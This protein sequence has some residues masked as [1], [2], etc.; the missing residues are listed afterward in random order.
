MGMVKDNKNMFK[1]GLFLA[2][3]I[4][5]ISVSFAQLP[6]YEYARTITITA[7]SIV[8]SDFTH[9]ITIDTATLISEGK[10]DIGCTELDF[11]DSNDNKYYFYPRY[12][13]S[14]ETIFLV[15]VNDSIIGAGTLDITM[16]YGSQSNTPSDH[17]RRE[18]V[19]LLLDD[20]NNAGDY[21][22]DAG[23]CT[24]TNETTALRIDATSASSETCSRILPTATSGSG[25][26]QLEGVVRDDEQ[27][28]F[29]ISPS[30]GT[31]SD[32]M[33]Q[34]DWDKPFSDIFSYEDGGT[35]TLVSPYPNMTIRF[36]YDWDEDSDT[37][38]YYIWNNNTGALL[39]SAT[40]TS[41]PS[42][43]SPTNVDRFFWF[44]NNQDFDALYQYLLL[45][46]S[47]DSSPSYSIGSE[48]SFTPPFYELTVND[49]GG[50]STV[51]FSV[52]ITNSTK[53]FVSS[54]NI[55]SIN[56][57]KSTI[58][59]NE[60]TVI[61]SAT[62]YEPLTYTE[63][64]DDNQEN[65]TASKL[66]S[67]FSYFYAYK[68]DLGVNANNFS[69][70]F[71]NN[72]QSSSS[73][74]SE[75]STV[76][77]LLTVSQ[78]QTP[79]G[80]VNLE[81]MLYGYNNKIQ[82]HNYTNDNAV[83]M[84]FNFTRSGFTVYFFEEETLAELTNVSVLISNSTVVVNASNLSGSFNVNTSEMPLGEI[85]V[86]VLYL[87]GNRNYYLTL[88]NNQTQI[89]NT[90]F[91]PIVDSLFFTWYTLVGSTP[92]SDSLVTIQRYVN[93]TF[94]TVV[95]SASQEDGS[96]VTLVRTNVQHNIIVS[97]DNYETKSFSYT[98]SP[99]LVNNPIYVQMTATNST[100]VNIPVNTWISDS[101]YQEF[102]PNNT[103]WNGTVSTIVSDSEG[104][105]S[106]V[107]LNVTRSFFDNSSAFFVVNLT[108]SQSYT[109][110]VNI[111]E[112][113]FYD[114][115]LIV[116]RNG[117][118]YTLSK[119]YYNTANL[120]GVGDFNAEQFEADG[121]LSVFAVK[122]IY[123]LLVFAFVVMSYPFIG[124]SVVFLLPAVAVLGAYWGILTVYEAILMFILSLVAIKAV[125]S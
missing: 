8:P 85:T 3:A 69:V 125:S 79:F 104:L 30:D 45:R 123:F 27:R 102:I 91:P 42:L 64:I 76:N 106:Y 47:V 115:N 18:Q 43:G 16:Q 51:T 114:F 98:F 118:V 24:I 94:R 84:T 34:V 59:L 41:I 53:S 95:Q 116:L 21:A 20:G 29:T 60:V 72:S 97:R 54:G 82:Q 22:S 65:Q 26:Y 9:N 63:T 23:N 5:F 56:I 122:I 58:P 38:S 33:F 78:N 62:G 48:Q 73:P 74:F 13:N 49:Y 37:A 25:H 75:L 109:I 57:S 108:G 39:G 86:N 2:M 46:L 31:T 44:D 119:T 35:Q 4:M 113:G 120:T 103:Y 111:T 92:L 88:L 12:C 1:T 68:N 32:R 117:T 87:G 121:G 50:I 112:Q 10:L 55:Q 107:Y 71:Y 101:L 100:G 15:K 61:L 19:A 14:A 77:G 99:A 7:G 40:G 105:L 83:N 66:L 6:D 28:V 80:I 11:T 89:L 96:A 90:Y 110:D 93:G 17:R 67:K 70:K 81:A 52:N 124:I 36:R